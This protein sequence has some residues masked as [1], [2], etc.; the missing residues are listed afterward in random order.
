MVR[1][2]WQQKTALPGTKGNVL[3]AVRENEPAKQT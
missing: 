3:D 1:Y 2:T